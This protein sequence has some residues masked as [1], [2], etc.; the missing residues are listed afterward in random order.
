VGEF[1]EQAARVAQ[2]RVGEGEQ[3]VAERRRLRLLQVG[4]VRHERV[5]VSLGPVGERRGERRGRRHEVEQLCPHRDPQRDPDGLAPGP[6]GP[7]PP[8][9]GA[10]PC[11][12]VPLA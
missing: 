8:G 11:G 10:D 2:H 4:V 7:Q 5:D 9:V 3:V 6:A 1:G 12:Q